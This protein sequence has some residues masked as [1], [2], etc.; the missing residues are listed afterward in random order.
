MNDDRRKPACMTTAEY[1][2]WC[3]A[4]DACLGRT[5]ARSPCRDCPL[6]WALEQEAKGD[7]L[8]WNGLD[9]VLGDPGGDIT[10]GGDP[11]PL[12]RAERAR[13]S[14]LRRGQRA[15]VVSSGRLD[16]MREAWGLH[17]EGLSGRQIA[18]RM[19]IHYGTVRMY[20]R[21]MRTRI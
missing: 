14:K 19:G 3:R 4:S 21:E 7:C 15:T 13:R 8:V 9:Y 2:A 11:I 1:D 20:I 5:R 16:R 6:A 10:K 17:Q 18:Q 12:T